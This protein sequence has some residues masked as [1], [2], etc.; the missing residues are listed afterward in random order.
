MFTMA[1]GTAL[2]RSWN[3]S[4]D[5]PDPNVSFS[6]KYIIHQ[7]NPHFIFPRPWLMTSCSS[8]AFPALQQQIFKDNIKLIIPIKSRYLIQGA[9]CIISSLIV[10]LNFIFAL[11]LSAFSLRYF[12]LI[13]TIQVVNNFKGAGECALHVSDHLCKSK[14]PFLENN[15]LFNVSA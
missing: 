5:S 1:Q 4:K 7:N 8:S 9:F 3:S 14:F 15:L 2:L 6:Y 13:R 12:F 11:N 10:L